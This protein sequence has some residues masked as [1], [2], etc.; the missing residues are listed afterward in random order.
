MKTRVTQTDVARVAGVHNTTVSLALRNSPAIPE[1]TRKRIQEI[2]E[3]LGYQPDPVL[4]AL[5]AYRNGRMA[6]R[7][8]DTLAYVTNWD[9][10]WGWRA[11]P[12]HEQ[13]WQGAQRKAAEFGYQLE[14]FWLGEPDL[15]PRR[16]S[17]MLFHRGV[18]GVLLASQLP[19]KGGLDD[20]DWSR[21]C[22]VKIGTRPQAPALHRVTSDHAGI[23]RLAMRGVLAA[24]YRRIGFVLPQWWDEL[25]DHAWSAGFQLEQRRL[26]IDTRIPLLSGWSRAAA[27]PDASGLSELTAIEALERWYRKHRPEVIVGYDSTVLGRVERA[28][29]AVPRDV[30]Y[31]DLSADRNDHRLAGV[32]PHGERV[33]EIAV[34]A[35]S[36]Y[37]QQNL[38]GLPDVPTTTLVEGGWVAGRSLP[39]LRLPPP[40]AGESASCPPFVSD[41]IPASA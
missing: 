9:T 29:L 16:L 14:H 27:G 10:R 41:A 18:T 28:G 37:L 35:L 26:P 22:A 24:G 1:P 39:A 23:V 11:I 30:G 32:C 38:F 25:A 20:F 5:V 12:G 13:A 4:R 34:E 19:L 31:V 7:R 36:G 3:Q 6:Q 40:W 15:T 33:G 8:K 2:A 17:D 21:L